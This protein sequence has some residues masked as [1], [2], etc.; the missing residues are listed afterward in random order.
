M[1]QAITARVDAKDDGATLAAVVR[2]LLGQMPWSKARDLVASGRVYVDGER[3]SDAAARVRA[4]S[5]IRVEP[6]AARV[7]AGV[8]DRERVVHLD[9]DVI[10]VDKPAGVVTVPY[11]ETDRDTLVDQ[12]RAL[13]RRIDRAR[14]PM[15]GVVQRLDKDTTGLIVFAR[16]MRAKRALEEQI[17]AHTVLRRYLA[18]V[19]GHARSGTRES[20]IVQDRGDGLRGSWGTRPE[21]RGDPPKDAKHAVTH[22][23]VKRTLARATLLECR[24]ETGRQ[25]QIRIHVSEMGHPLVGETVYIRNYSGERIE[26]PRPMLHAAELGFAH[27]RDGKQVSWRSPLPDDFQRALAAEP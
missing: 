14:D 3:V 20:W 1:A 21:H 23:Q 17:R 8:L 11:E 22:F 4:G 26:A 6:E 19:H 24:L 5:E 25:H 13:L 12:V 10:V 2:A 9:A 18:L 15:A 7:R 16:N 27:P